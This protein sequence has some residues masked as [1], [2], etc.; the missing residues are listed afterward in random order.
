MTYDLQHSLVN[1]LILPK[2]CMLGVFSPRHPRPGDGS[3]MSREKSG[4]YNF[5]KPERTRPY[6]WSISKLLVFMEFRMKGGVEVDKYKD[7]FLLACYLAILPRLEYSICY[8]FLAMYS[9]IPFA[10]CSLPTDQ[11]STPAVSVCNLNFHRSLFLT[12]ASTVSLSPDLSRDI[13]MLY[14][15]CFSLALFVLI[16]HFF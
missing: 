16:V 13:L 11:L 1:Q 3:L 6:T 8:F 9:Q 14:M 15:F 5:L 7:V 2:M 12:S 10:G 4:V